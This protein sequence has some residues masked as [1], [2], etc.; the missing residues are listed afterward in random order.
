M[1]YVY[2][3]AKIEIG[4][5]MVS[6][7][8]ADGSLGITLLPVDDVTGILGGQPRPDMPATGVSWNEAATG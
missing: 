5:D 1:D 3:M 8:N 4:R 2:R 7:A 6:K